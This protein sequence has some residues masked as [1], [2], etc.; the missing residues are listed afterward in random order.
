ME[1]NTIVKGIYRYKTPLKWIGRIFL[2]LV[3]LGVALVIAA[4]WYVESNQE[5]I[6]KQLLTE[7]NKDLNG[8]LKIGELHPKLLSGFPR[9]SIALSDISLTDDKFQQ[10]KKPLLLAKNVEV[11]VNALKMIIGTISIERIYLEDAKVFILTDSL[12]YTNTSIFK[13]SPEKPKS[14]ESNSMAELH[15]V[16]IKNLHFTAD[17]QQRNKIFEYQIESLKGNIEFDS[18]GWK[19]HVRLKTFAQNMSFNKKYGSFMNKKWVDGHLDLDFNS[20]KKQ[21]I[22]HPDELKIGDENFLIS[23]QFDFKPETTF[24]KIK[25]D[26]P[27]I[28]WSAASDLLANNINKKLNWFK[29]NKPIAVVCTIDGDFNSEEDPVIIV[30]AT[31]Q[32]VTLETPG[33]IVNNCSFDGLFH[34]TFLKNKGSNDANSAIILKNFKGKYTQL[35]FEMPLFS[36]YNLDHPMAKGKIISNFKVA[37]FN[38]IL[39]KDLLDF[40]SGK[41]NFNFDFVADIE[42]FQL[43]RPKFKGQFHIKDAS[44]RYEPGNMNLKNIHADLQFTDN[45]LLV[46]TIQLK[47]GKSKIQLSGKAANFLKFLYENPKLVQADLQMHAPELYLSEIMGYLNKATV[48][49]KTRVK[50]KGNF[51]QELSEVFDQM[52]LNFALKVDRLHHNKFLAQNVITQI[53]IGENEINLKKTTFSHANG[54]MEISGQIAGLN[55][56]PYFDLKAQAFGVD[57]SE[58]FRQFN[59]FGVTSMQ[60]QNLK[61]RFYFITNLKGRISK[62]GDLIAN[63]MNGQAKF[64]LK[65]GRIINFDPIRNVG[66]YAFPNRNLNDIQLQEL[67]G[68]FLIQGDKVQIEPMKISSSVLNLDIDGIYAFNKGTALYVDVPLRDPKRDAE[69]TDEKELQERRHRGVVLHLFAEDDPKTGKVKM[70]LLRKRQKENLQKTSG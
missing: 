39:D 17:N 51:T 69:I 70:K 12:G 60:P 2:G 14:E 27:K 6:R 15:Q 29:M 53:S 21:L 19:S 41:G 65:N 30:N 31:V 26:N 22:L 32:D 1:K 56:Q 52:K 46:E 45:D 8:E 23:A 36:I 61:G 33:G 20:D 40:T 18:D 7:L 59:S 3:V 38:G 10:H 28:T 64:T 25:I 11:D 35:P 47:T 58:F 34:N 55:Q 43:V 63:S 62:S 13:K 5:K 42:N 68:S 4:F 54:N 16:V 50:K 9:L 24:Y 57:V 37:D 49:S 66:K 44:I 48:E 67:N